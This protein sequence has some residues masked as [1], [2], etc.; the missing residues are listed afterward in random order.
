MDSSE[1]IEP[2]GIASDDAMAEAAYLVERG[3]RP[4]ALCGT[5]T[6]AS[7]IE[8]MLL[9]QRLNAAVNNRNVKQFIVDFGDGIAQ[10]GFVAAG[11]V[12]DLYQ[13]VLFTDIPSVQ[14]ERIF[15]LMF[16][17]GIESIA[18]YEDLSNGRLIVA[19]ISS[20]L[21]EGASK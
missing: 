14:R 13:W 6:I 21:V 3:V 12:L 9:M 16:G 2:K 19:P 10:Y 4:I 8:R 15:G 20:R 7:E 18:R 1:L 5:V 17:Y 11:W